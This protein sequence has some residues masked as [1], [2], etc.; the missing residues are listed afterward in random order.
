MEFKD[1]VAVI[2]GSASGIGRS[3]ALALARLGTDIVIADIN[4]KRMA[5]VNEEI[6]SLGRRV[7][8][9]HCDVSKDKDMDNL[10]A[11]TLSTMG[12]VDILMNNAGVMLRGFPDKLTM[13]DWDWILGINLLGV[14]RGL[15][16][17]LPHMI[18]RGDGYIINTSSI[19]GLISG[20]PY[21]VAYTTSKFAVTALTECLYNYLQPRGIGVSLLCPGGVATNIIESF[22]FVGDPPEILGGRVAPSLERPGVAHP[23]D[24]AQMVIE[25]MKQNRFLIL[26][27][28]PRLHP[29]VMRSAEDIQ[30]FLDGQRTGRGLGTPGGL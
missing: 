2:T 23:D 22:R 18:E 17:F 14:I 3:M 24:V 4:D 9:V 15:R 25:A 13:A 28:P 27:D 8:A 12:K 11:E 7:L 29:A 20:V 1:K 30:K 21:S 6:K 26:T 5:E 16:V 19:G 10:A